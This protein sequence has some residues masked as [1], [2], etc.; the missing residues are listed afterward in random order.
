MDDLMI[1]DYQIAN[2]ITINSILSNY[3]VNVKNACRI[4]EDYGDTKSDPYFKI[5]QYRPH[6]QE[7]DQMD[8]ETKLMLV[9][10]DRDETPV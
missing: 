6:Q 3:I 7:I 1:H 8:Y 2:S 4:M 9:M 5:L 10:K